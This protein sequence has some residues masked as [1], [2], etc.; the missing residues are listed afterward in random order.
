MVKNNPTN[1]QEDS[2]D[3]R[4]IYKYKTE[5]NNKDIYE[6]VYHGSKI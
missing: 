3:D 2:K 5:D 4:K 6:R 1:R